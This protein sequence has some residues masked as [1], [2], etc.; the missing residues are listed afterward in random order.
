MG[1]PDYD[2]PSNQ[3]VGGAGTPEARRWDESWDAFDRQSWDPDTPG[4]AECLESLRAMSSLLAEDQRFWNLS[5]KHVFFNLIHDFQYDVID[6]WYDEDEGFDVTQTWVYKEHEGLPLSWFARLLLSSILG[7]VANLKPLKTD[8]PARTDLDRYVDL[9]RKAEA[10]DDPLSYALFLKA[11]RRRFRDDAV[12]ERVNVKRFID[13][14]ITILEDPVPVLG[15]PNPGLDWG[16][17]EV[18]VRG[19]IAEGNTTMW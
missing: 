17:I 10:A 9:V 12:V 5:A 3:Q 7:P 8:D 19:A 15:E 13:E 11:A 1:Q 18:T 14:M 4:D 6:S 16:W 2:D